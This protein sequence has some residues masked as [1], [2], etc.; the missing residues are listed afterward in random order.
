MTV[1]I[2]KMPQ[3]ENITNSGRVGHSDPAYRHSAYPK[4]IVFSPE[5]E[6]A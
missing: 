2:L 6:R 3:V 4:G 5:S 1:E